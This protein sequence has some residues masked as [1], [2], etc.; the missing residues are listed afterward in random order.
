MSTF[1]NTDRCTDIILDFIK[2]G[3]PGNPV[4]EAKGNYNAK[5]G[6]IN[7]SENLARL[8]LNQ[9]MRMQATFVPQWPSTAIGA[10]QF[11]KG[12]LAGMISN[13]ANNLTGN[14]LFTPELQD[15][16]AVILL[17]RRGYSK[18]W[19][20][21][22]T[23]DEFAHRL[24]MEWASLPDP[25]NAGK[26]HYHG[27]AAGNHA[28]TTL[29]AVHAMLHAA[30]AA[31]GTPAAAAISPAP[32]GIIEPEPQLSPLETLKAIQSALIDGGYYPETID[33]KSSVDGDFGP[34][35]REAFNDAL[36]A[37]YQKRM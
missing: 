22:I 5:I 17:V 18:W 14:E 25:E 32:A 1:V 33:G 7:S 2:G 31:K 10:Y 12:T 30:E 4:G 15:R 6:R 21:R 27:D 29:A 36:E 23:N 9:I 35:S 24:S 28:S 34:I 3:V 16:L 11:L 8:T 37:A 19:Q 13:P 26:S 20:G